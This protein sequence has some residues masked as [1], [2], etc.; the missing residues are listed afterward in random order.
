MLYIIKIEI[1]HKLFMTW[2]ILTMNLIDCWHDLY[3]S[4]ERVCAVLPRCCHAVETAEGPG[5]RQACVQSRWPDRRPL[6]HIKNSPWFCDAAIS[7]KASLKNE[8]PS[9]C[10]DLALWRAEE[11]RSKVEVKPCL[12]ARDVSCPC[13]SCISSAAFVHNHHSLRPPILLRLI[14]G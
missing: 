6:P 5:A 13:D 1:V 3:V 7:N 10:F 9:P 8:R 11:E 4:G 12:G 2:H 14:V